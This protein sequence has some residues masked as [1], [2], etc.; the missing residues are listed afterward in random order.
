MDQRICICFFRQTLLLSKTVRESDL[1]GGKLGPLVQR[2]YVIDSRLVTRK[3][4]WSK[5]SVQSEWK[6]NLREWGTLEPSLSDLG[7]RSMVIFRFE[8]G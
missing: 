2:R 5:R 8:D 4:A 1:N 6:A 7:E 3:Y